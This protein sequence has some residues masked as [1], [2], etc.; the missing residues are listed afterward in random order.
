[1]MNEIKKKNYWKPEENIIYIDEN[2]E[3]IYALWNWQAL[4][5]LDKFFEERKKL[6]NEPVEEKEYNSIAKKITITESDIVRWFETLYER[7]TVPRLLR[8]TR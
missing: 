1:V 8:R 4:K 3:K 7:E 6:T 2:I 5:R